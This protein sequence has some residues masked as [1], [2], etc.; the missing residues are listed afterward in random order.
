MCRLPLA[1]LQMFLHQLPT[2][3][4]I[5]LSLLPIILFFG[6]FQVVSLRLAKDVSRFRGTRLHVWPGTRPLSHQEPTGF[7]P[8]G[9]YWGASSQRRNTA[10]SHPH[11]NSSAISSSKAEPAVYV[12][13]RQVEEITDSHLRL[14]HGDEPFPRRGDFHSA[15]AERAAARLWFLLPATPSPLKRL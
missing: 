6:L 15:D 13:N 12:L 14:R 8:A 1:L 11:R 9:T 4:E 5:A 7:M 3:L 10:I 2:Y